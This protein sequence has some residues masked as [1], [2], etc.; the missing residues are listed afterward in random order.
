MALPAPAGPI[1]VTVLTGFL[2]AG[3]TTLLNRLL[4][5]PAT[6]PTA[7]VVNEF[8][9][10]GIDGSL[11]AGGVD[12]GRRGQPSDRIVELRNGCVCC[13]VRGDLQ[14]AVGELLERRAAPWWQPW[15]RPLRFGRLLIETSGLATPG[16]LIQTFVI[17]PALATATRVDGVIALAHAAKIREQLLLHPEAQA[18]IACSDRIIINHID[19]L[20]G[21]E[22]A[23]ELALV[24]EEIRC[25]AP[26]AQV[27][28]AGR[29]AVAHGPLLDIG[30]QEPGRWQP[31][32][33]GADGRAIHSSGIA[34]QSWR[35][36]QAIELPKLKMFLQFLTARR[37][38]EL[39]RLKGIFRC[40][41]VREAV[42]A[43]GMHQWLELGP[44]QMPAP[45]E[46]RLVVI[47]RGLDAGELER[48]WKAITG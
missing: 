32:D 26:L 31:G 22:G 46:S 30:G 5:D 15:R 45:A 44:A 18:Q 27:Q 28:T 25:L 3:K 36:D 20:T 34:T 12:A 24:Q 47:G 8:G 21:P 7:V 19:R 2:G 48:G 23:A 41:G 10:L 11:I 42:V 13:E 6:P 9:A 35:T 37:S 1:P 17:D 33:V 4:A 14:R 29:A 40:A 43:Q 16:P 39:L 38:W